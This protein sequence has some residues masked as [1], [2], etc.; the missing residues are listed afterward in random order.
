[1]RLTP[2][3]MMWPLLAVALCVWQTSQQ[4]VV[5]RSNLTLW[6][7]AA[8]LSTQKPRVAHNYGLALLEAGETTAAIEQFRQAATLASAPHVPAWDRR[9]T[10]RDVVA[11]MLALRGA[12]TR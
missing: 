5:W 8:A 10:N 1:M 6:R 3:G 7:H 12:L 11:N 4:I 2:Q 9:I